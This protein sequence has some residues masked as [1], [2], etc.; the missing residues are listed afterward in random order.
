MSAVMKQDDNAPAISEAALV[1]VQV[2]AKARVG[3][4]G[5]GERCRART[6]GEGDVPHAEPIE[7]LQQEGRPD[8]VEG[9]MLAGKRAVLRQLAGGHKAL[10]VR[11]R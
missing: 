8:V 10:A 2:T 5:H 6:R 9:G 4:G 7:L 1:E 3:G 11:K